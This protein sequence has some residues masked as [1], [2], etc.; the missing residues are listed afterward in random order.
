MTK[1]LPYAT[2]QNTA[3]ENAITAGAAPNGSSMQGNPDAVNRA[4][5]MGNYPPGPQVGGAGQTL[6]APL[7]HDTIARG[8]VPLNAQPSN[9]VQ[10]APGAQ[11]LLALISSGQVSLNQSNYGQP[12]SVPVGG[13]SPQAQNAQA[14]PQPTGAGSS[15]TVPAAPIYLGD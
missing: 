10:A 14:Q 7:M 12:V 4:Q 13:N 6:S 5:D 11:S 2:I 9:L 15:V 1:L 8:G 3:G